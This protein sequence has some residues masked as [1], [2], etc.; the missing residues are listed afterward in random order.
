MLK[1]HS[2][3][4]ANLSSLFISAAPCGTRGL[5]VTQVMLASAWGLLDRSVGD[6]LTGHLVTQLIGR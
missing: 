5:L 3:T 4:E 1:T 6:P 2:L